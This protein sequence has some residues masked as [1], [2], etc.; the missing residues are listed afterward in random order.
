MTKQVNI[1]NLFE[2]KTI[3]FKC[4]KCL[5]VIE[6]SI[7]TPSIVQKE[8]PA[9]GANFDMHYFR[10]LAQ[11]KSGLCELKTVK[12]ADDKSAEIEILTEIDH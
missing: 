5:T 1:T 6:S 3:R 2:V 4:N 10:A 12:E 8:C 11:V 9:C 7:T